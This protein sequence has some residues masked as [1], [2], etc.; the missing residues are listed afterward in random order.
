MQGRLDTGLIW[1]GGKERAD[2][3]LVGPRHARREGPGQ[4]YAF[5]CW[6]SGPELSTAS[7]ECSG[8]VTV[9]QFRPRNLG[10]GGGRESD[11]HSCRLFSSFHSAINRRREAPTAFRAQLRTHQNPPA[12]PPQRA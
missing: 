1:S 7:T 9:G 5:A 11:A 10:S 6:S 2:A 3:K 12:R 4:P 8:S